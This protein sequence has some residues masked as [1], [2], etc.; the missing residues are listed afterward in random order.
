MHIVNKFNI[1]HPQDAEGCN[2]VVC[3]KKCATDLKKMLDSGNRLLWKSDGKD[4]LT[5]PRTSEAILVEWM[6][7]GDNYIK[8]RGYQNNGVRKLDQCQKIADII[9]RAG[10][11]KKRS[12]KDVHTK[13]CQIEAHMR[14]AL[15]YERSDTGVGLMYGNAAEKETFREKILLKCKHFDILEDFFRDRAMGNATVTDKDVCDENG[16]LVDTSDE[17]E[18]SQDDELD[19]NVVQTGNK[20]GEQETDNFDIVMTVPRNRALVQNGS[21]ASPIARIDAM[22]LRGAPDSESDVSRSV[23]SRLK[24]KAVTREKKTLSELFEE[25]TMQLREDKKKARALETKMKQQEIDLKKEENHLKRQKMEDSKDK[26]KWEALASQKDYE[27]KDLKYRMELIDK[28][29][30]LRQKNYDYKQIAEL[31]PSLIDVFPAE[32]KAKYK[33]V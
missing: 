16:F 12:K 22:T 4:G 2:V 11:M 14:K 10:V 18:E 19:N 27:M 29:Q 21:L 17:E 20:E 1:S 23:A 13:I 33:N 7:Q 15:D 26:L 5:D 30:E 31:I 25:E 32:E 8:Y 6:T 9:N 28:L 3:T 24:K